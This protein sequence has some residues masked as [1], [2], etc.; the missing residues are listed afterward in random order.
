MTLVYTIIRNIRFHCKFKCW[1][2]NYC[3]MFS[4]KR[5]YYDQFV[6][7]Q[8]IESTFIKEIGTIRLLTIVNRNVLLLKNQISSSFEFH[9]Y[10]LIYWFKKRETFM[11]REKL[12]AINYNHFKLDFLQIKS[13]RSIC[14]I[15]FL[16]K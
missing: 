3:I 15:T 9:Y 10:L 1:G 11:K 5:L 6:G 4:L 13:S 14:Y 8:Y 16:S 7:F 2:Y 12:L